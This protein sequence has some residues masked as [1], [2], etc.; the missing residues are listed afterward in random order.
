MFI[1][2]PTGTGKTLAYVIPVIQRILSS[3][4]P[5]SAVVAVPHSSLVQQLQYVVQCIEQKLITQLP[6]P[7]SQIITANTPS[8]S[9][10]PILIG[11]PSNLHRALQSHSQPL[12]SIV[13]DEADQQL[14][15]KS[16]YGDY[17]SELLHHADDSVASH[18]LT[19]L[20][21]K[22]ADIQ[23]VFASAT[24]S[25]AAIHRLNKHG[26]YGQRAVLHVDNN[27]TDVS[28][29]K[30]SRD[31][32]YSP[33]TL[34]HCIYIT[35]T[36]STSTSLYDDYYA[37]SDTRDSCRAVQQLLQ[38]TH[39]N[40]LYLCLDATMGATELQLQELGVQYTLLADQLQ[41]VN[42]LY[43]QLKRSSNMLLVG[44]VNT[45][46]GL[47]LP[48]ISTVFVGVPMSILTPHTYSHASGRAGRSGNQG[49][50]VLLCKQK[51]RWRLKQLQSLCNVEFKNINT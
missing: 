26:Y 21:S 22:H 8:V 29:L 1:H 16:K 2:A 18:L 38:T 4:K 23:S 37:G 28:R 13:I 11:Q 49:T 45:V 39:G 51:D 36:H 17:S 30:Q 34:Q 7:L 5:Y 19:T 42:Q 15:P 20:T 9:R 43:D 12:H 41:H 35:D 44:S 46:R 14:I 47:D 25:D 33:V 32:V 24:V 48:N 31:E 50:S 3:D 27:S 10:N 6:Q 40:A